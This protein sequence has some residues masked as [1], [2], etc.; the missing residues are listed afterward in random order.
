MRQ[1]AGPGESARLITDYALKMAPFSATTAKRSSS[2]RG[3]IDPRGGGR[4]PIDKKFALDDKLGNDITSPALARGLQEHTKS[5]H[6]D[7]LNQSL[8]SGLS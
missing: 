6:P 1:L 2:L 4:E 3:Y 8:P 7:Q 5:P